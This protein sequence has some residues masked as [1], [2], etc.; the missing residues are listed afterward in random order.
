MSPSCV[1]TRVSIAVSL[2][3]ALRSVEVTFV[4]QAFL[5]FHTTTGWCDSLSRL[6]VISRRSILF[7]V[8]VLLAQQP[9]K[10]EPTT[11]GWGPLLPMVAVFALLYFMLIL[12]M[13]RREQQQKLA[14]Q[15]A[16]KKNARVVT[17]S[18]I[19]GTVAAV[20]ENGEISLKIDDSSPVKIRMLKTSIAQ[21]LSDEAGKESPAKPAG[22]ASTAIKT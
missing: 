1:T 15:N 8:M 16:L 5:T 17:H 18:G 9:T 3:D 2:P 7:N 14:V 22:D 6:M 10:N 19:I 11:P 4:G 21:V 20:H 13:R 12:P